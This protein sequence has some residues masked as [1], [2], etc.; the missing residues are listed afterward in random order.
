MLLNRNLSFKKLDDSTHRT[1]K[2]QEIYLQTY[3]FKR[4]ILIRTQNR[5]SFAFESAGRWTVR[6]GFWEVELKMEKNLTKA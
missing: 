5:Q 6:I 1:M 3:E 4:K 2:H